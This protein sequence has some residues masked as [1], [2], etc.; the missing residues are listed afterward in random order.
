MK[1]VRFFGEPL[2]RV[3]LVWIRKFDKLVAT[4]HQFNSKNHDILAEKYEGSLETIQALKGRIV[5][6]VTSKEKSWL[7]EA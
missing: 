2:K 6:I 3:W 5:T 1:I 4:F 7:I